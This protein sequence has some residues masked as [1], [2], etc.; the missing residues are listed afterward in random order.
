MQCNA[1]TTTR[2]PQPIFSSPFT[3]DLFYLFITF[4]FKH[5]G[6]LLTLHSI[7]FMCCVLLCHTNA[8]TTTEQP[9][10]RTIANP[11]LL[12][13]EMQQFLS[14]QKARFGRRAGNNNSS[15][16]S[17]GK[18]AMPGLGENRNPSGRRQAPQQPPS[19]S[20]PDRGE[21][22]DPPPQR[23][24]PPPQQPPVTQQPLYND[25]R[26]Q[27]LE[28]ERRYRGGPSSFE[29]PRA[30]SAR[31]PSGSAPMANHYNANQ[32]PRTDYMPERRVRFDAEYQ[33]EPPSTYDP[34]I[35][36][37]LTELEMLLRD[38][39]ATR[40]RGS[41]R[42]M[43]LDFDPPSAPPPNPRSMMEAPSSSSS[44]MPA[45]EQNRGGDNNR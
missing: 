28:Q 9:N 26:S 11:S 15:G 27:L 8:T 40:S 18:S 5:H 21:N 12:H 4:D 6:A 42:P 19:L 20:M 33:R 24:A 1:T 34:E 45:A 13:R 22:R 41:S 25:R 36:L 30:A 3:C 32:R 2:Q 7:Q 14:S 23:Q 35:T 31:Y 44:R 43:R 38:R 39:R 16:N 10:N 17:G 37:G 29:A